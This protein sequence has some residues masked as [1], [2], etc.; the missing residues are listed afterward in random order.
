MVIFIGAATGHREQC[1]RSVLHWKPS[2]EITSL[3]VS[4]LNVLWLNDIV[5]GNIVVCFMSSIQNCL[6]R[7][8]VEF[9]VFPE[10]S[11]NF[12]RRS[13]YA[14]GCVIAMILVNFPLVASPFSWWWMAT[15]HPLVRPVGRQQ[16][17]SY[18]EP[19]DT[20][21]YPKKNND[22][23]FVGHFDRNRSEPPNV[24]T[25]LPLTILKAGRAPYSPQ[26]GCN[27]PD[28]VQEPHAITLCKLRPFHK[29]YDVIPCTCTC[30]VETKRMRSKWHILTS[31]SILSVRPIGWSVE[32]TLKSNPFCVDRSLPDAFT[33]QLKVIARANT[34]AWFCPGN[35]VDLYIVPYVCLLRKNCDFF[36][37]K[38]LLRM[39]LPPQCILC[40][41]FVLASWWWIASMS[42]Q[43]GFI[44]KEERH[45]K[46]ISQY[47]WIGPAFPWAHVDIAHCGLLRMDLQWRS[48]GGDQRLMKRPSQQSLLYEGRCQIPPSAS[49]RGTSVSIFKENKLFLRMTSHSILEDSVTSAAIRRLPRNW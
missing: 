14:A 28:G 33:W 30:N 10:N 34:S 18:N 16:L 31:N 43:K 38:V 46:A 20:S 1:A 11:Q 25:F 13:Q 41:L 22:C 2:G 40:S 8:N 48:L 4:W 39:F 7:L 47:I 15:V 24:S 32:G 27:H 21:L 44:P 37:H 19:N 3:R 36:M 26:Q 49:S 45:S 6:M 29:V 42:H 5:I 12:M 9:N 35:S 23:A 17:F